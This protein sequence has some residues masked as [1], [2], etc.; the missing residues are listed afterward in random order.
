MADTPMKVSEMAAR[1]LAIPGREDPDPVE[2]SLNSSTGLITATDGVTDDE[3]QLSTQAGKT[4]TPG[5]SSQTAVASGKYTTGTVTVAGDADL[6][7]SNIKKDVNIFGVTGTYAGIEP[8]PIT[9]ELTPSTGI[10]VATDG[11][12]S[13]QLQL[14]VQGSRTITPGTSQQTAV[15]SGKF[16]T[17][18]ILVE[19][20]AD[21]KA[22]NI[23]KDVNIFGV[24][25]TLA[26]PSVPFTFSINTS[27][28]QVSANDGVLSSTYNQPTV[29]GGTFDVTWTASSSNQVLVDGGKFL[30]S[31]VKIA[32]EP[33]FIGANIKKGV[34]MWGVNGEF[35][36]ID[37]LSYKIT[38]WQVPLEEADPTRVGWYFPLP[39]G[40]P[41]GLPKLLMAHNP[42]TS[43]TA[44]PQGYWQ[45]G[46]CA[47]I[48]RSASAYYAWGIW[49]E[50]TYGTVSNSRIEN[51]QCPTNASSS[52]ALC[53][54]RETIN[55]K[56]SVVFTM[57][58]YLSKSPL[59]TLDANYHKLQCFW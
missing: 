52:S 31:Q 9:L 39:S 15:A 1:I 5:T 30:T 21:L 24:V 51:N 25:G 22:A 37:P 11:I 7:A 18:N 56:D 19:G 50:N 49:Y 40:V 45:P 38:D 13:N 42:L 47:Y 53:I 16:T 2:I 33:N 28:G 46:P 58:T 36:G 35:D 12:T 55:G 44:L 8:D 4:V 32:K 10:V 17:G 6:V 23:K 41:D 27:S 26:T 57:K 54:T 59:G 29:A 3:L 20:D 34:S 43:A 14:P 48:L